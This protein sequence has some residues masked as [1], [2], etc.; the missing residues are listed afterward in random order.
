MAAPD[1]NILHRD[2]VAKLAGEPSFA[3]GETY[4]R[5]GRV[6]TLARHEMSLT[7]LVRGS[8]RYLVRLWVGDNNLAF[9]CTCPQGQ[10]SVFCKHAVAVALAWIAKSRVPS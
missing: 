2:V 3:R 8:D 7:G 1:A 10:E 4:F 6:L 9:A 5:E